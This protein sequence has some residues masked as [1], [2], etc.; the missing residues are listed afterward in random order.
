MC[1]I[2][3]ELASIGKEKYSDIPIGFDKIFLK[4]G[5]NYHRLNINPDKTYEFIHLTEGMLKDEKIEIV[6]PGRSRGRGIAPILFRDTAEYVLVPAGEPTD[7]TKHSAFIEMLIEY[8]EK[9]DDDA[10]KIILEVLSKG[11]EFPSNMKPKDW[12]IIDYDNQNY[13]LSSNFQ[14]YWTNFVQSTFHLSKRYVCSVCGEGKDTLQ[15][16]PFSISDSWG[17]AK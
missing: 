6:V 4:K 17:R 16:V 13:H 12:I 3:R 1:N 9:I 14:Q 15:R 8:A 5:K 2:L 7:G 10:S 11:I